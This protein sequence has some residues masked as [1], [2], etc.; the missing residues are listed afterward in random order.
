MEFILDKILKFFW[1]WDIIMIQVR[2]ETFQFRVGEPSTSSAS[3]NLVTNWENF[4]CKI[5]DYDYSGMSGII[6]IYYIPC[7]IIYKS[8]K[9]YGV[10]S[11]IYREH[12]RMGMF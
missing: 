4:V 6:V 3:T 12:Q 1:K 9:V 11:W 2:R 10:I 5:K 7:I 8:I